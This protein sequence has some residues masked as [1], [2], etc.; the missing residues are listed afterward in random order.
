LLLKPFPPTH[1]LPPHYPPPTYSLI[2]L[3]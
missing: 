2:Y 3:N 1:L